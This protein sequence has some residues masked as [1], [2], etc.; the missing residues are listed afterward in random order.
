[1]KILIPLWGKES[2][3]TESNVSI[4]IAQQFLARCLWVRCRGNLF[5]ESLGSNDSLLWLRYS[6]FQASYHHILD[7][8]YVIRNATSRDRAVVYIFSSGPWPL[9]Q[10]H[11]HFLQMVGLIGRVISLSQ[12]PYLTIGQHKHRI[13]AYTHTHTHTKHLYLKWDSS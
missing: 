10:F 13:N 9:I 6:G 12:G 8:A 3:S 2:V 7:T 4:A 1:M 11:N 5:T